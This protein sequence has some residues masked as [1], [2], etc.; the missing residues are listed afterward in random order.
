VRTDTSPGDTG[1]LRVEGTLGAANSLAQIPI[2][3]RGNWEKAQLGGLSRLLTGRDIGLRGG[4]SVDFSVA[5]AIGRNIISTDVTLTKA[6]RAEFVPAT[7]LSIEVG[8][9]SVAGDTFHSFTSIECHWPPA[10]SSDPPVAIVVGDVPDIRRPDAASAKLTVPGLSASALLEVLSVASRH[11]PTGLT[12]PGVLSGYIA[13]NPAG[14]APPE[15]A[16]KLRGGKNIGSDRP[17]TEPVW[18]GEL[19]F[20]GE[21]LELPAF[22]PRPVALGELLVRST[23]PTDAA[24][25]RSRGARAEVARSD[26]ASGFDLLPLALPLGGKQP[27]M[28]EGHFDGSGYTLHLSGNAVPARLLA[29][30]DAFPEFGDGLKELLDPALDPAADPA[31]APANAESASAGARR[32]D[33]AARNDSSTPVRIDVTASRAWGGPQVWRET[34][35]PLLHK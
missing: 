6:R 34:T 18:K 28:L 21:L 12:G 4:F 20:S 13:W 31:P 32:D 30:G 35:P 5:G 9:R 3:L 24:P 10:D 16:P 22:G 26:P 23:P 29:L 33:P 25:A 15:S 17:T 14:P 11:P 27:A 2:E 8:C 7:P 19:D 1:L